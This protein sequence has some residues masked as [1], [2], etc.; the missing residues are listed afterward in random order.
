MSPSGSPRQPVF[1]RLGYPLFGVG[2]SQWGTL[3]ADD[4]VSSLDGL[5]KWTFL[6]MGFCCF[7]AVVDELQAGR[8][9][10][11][12]WAI[13]LVWSVAGIAFGIAA[14]KS[15]FFEKLLA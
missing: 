5:L 6:G 10:A 2:F 9:S 15:S 1:P 12:S 3:M 11:Q 14:W 8:Y 7:I 4:N 13:A